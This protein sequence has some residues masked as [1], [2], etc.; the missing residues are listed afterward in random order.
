MTINKKRLILF[1]VLFFVLFAAVMYF[2]P[3][4]A[5]DAYYDYLNLT[6][7]YKIL[8]FAAGYGNGRVL[9]NL[10]AVIL[11][12]SQL[13]AAVFRSASVCGLVY[14]IVRLVNDKKGYNES[15]TASVALLT[16]GVGGLF[17]GEVFSWI[18]GFSNYIPPMLLTLICLCVIK[19]R[20]FKTDSLWIK[21]LTVT[22]LLLCGSAAQ[23]FTESNTLNAAL[24]SLII[25]LYCIFRKRDK[26]LYSFTYLIASGI[27]T[28]V[29]LYA[30]H[31]VHDKDGIY[32]TVNYSSK[33]DSLSN[34]FT[35]VQDIYSKFVCWLPKFFVLYIMLSIVLL[36][37]IYKGGGHLTKNVKAFVTFSLCAYPAYSVLASVLDNGN[38]ANSKMKYLY[39][40][41]TTLLFILYIIS[42]LV[43]GSLLEKK[44][45]F[46]FDFLVIFALFTSAYFTVL[47]PVNPR[48]IF[49]SYVVFIIAFCVVFDTA[50]AY[51]KINKNIVSKILKSGVFG[52]FAFL[53]PLYANI[54]V[55]NN[56][57][58]AYIDYQVKQGE[59]AVYV[60]PLTN[61]DYFHHSYASARLGYTYYHEEPNDVNFML[62]EQGSWLKNCYQ[63]GNFKS[64]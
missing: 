6:S 3:H 5:D 34:M 63:D 36:I 51:V 19:E 37:V 32:E 14:F 46:I 8:H 29:M 4:T 18:A 60:C 45:R 9:G 39:M 15:L 49:Y 33:I 38:F 20:S 57:V 58:N 40:A 59:K 41:F 23:L 13:F 26:L 56:Q 10:L 62:I 11:C 48:C 30:R 44:R 27:G 16:V 1:Y 22:G 31:F 35:N 64:Q 54:T 61:T 53:I 55:M 7:P 2:S 42:L 47:Y 50:L 43:C 17:F 28:G 24:L 12:K 21:I 52:M 25:L